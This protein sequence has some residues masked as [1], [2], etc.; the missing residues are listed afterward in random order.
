[1]KQLAVIFRIALRNLRQHK[2]KTI[3]IGT[4][5]AVGVIILVVGNSLM[6]TA[7]MGIQRAFI[8]NFTGDVMITGIAQGDISLFGVRSPGGIE[9]TPVLPEYEK[10][11]EYVENYRGINNFTPQVSGVASIRVE[12]QEKEN[13]R[14]LTFLIGVEPD[15]YHSMFTASRIVDGRLLEPGEEGVIIS[16]D[17]LKEIEERLEV[18]ISVG[19][20]LLLTS[21]GN[22]GIKI[23]EVPVIGVFNFDQF[24]DGMEFISFI[25]IQTLRALKGMTVGSL[26]ALDLDKEDIDFLD[27]ELD[28]D[29]MFAGESFE[30]GEESVSELNDD[31][32]ADILDSEEDVSIEEVKQLDSGAWEYILVK[33]GSSATSRRFIREI[34]QW[35]DSEELSAQA[36]DWKAAAG[37][38]STTADVVRIVFNFAVILVAIV[39]VIIVMNTLVISVVERTAEIGTMRALGAQKDFVRKLFT[40]EIVV[41]S[42]VFG[43]IGII[44]GMIILGI[45][46]LIAFPATNA[47]LEVLFAG[48]VLIPVL[49]PGKMLI[50]LIGVTLIC[51]IA[52]LYPLRL[53]LKV[54]PTEAMRTE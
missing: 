37:P 53:A 26:S 11:R 19:D 44:F 10:I 36:T 29:S 13:K 20:P 40:M 45:V 21:F 31:Q 16:E 15:T 30:V 34:N 7:T 46:S 17:N 35:F 33:T 39:A 25:D 32:F 6:D 49:Y 27:S 47:L 2:S 23:R 50:I 1:M 38:F 54:Q 48:E 14:A 22:K 3:I 12:G 9:E 8:D 52:N 43:L 28:M 42:F 5:I 24:S 51:V 18:T 41:I 4:I